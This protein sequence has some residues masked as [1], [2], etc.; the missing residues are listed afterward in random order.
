MNKRDY[1]R[2][3]RVMKYAGRKPSSSPA[4]GNKFL[5]GSEQKNFLAQALT[6]QSGQSES[7]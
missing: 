7:D 4:A 2:D 6:N 3:G 5:H 1:F